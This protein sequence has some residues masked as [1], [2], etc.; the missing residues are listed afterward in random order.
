MKK[1]NEKRTETKWSDEIWISSGEQAQVDWK[2]NI[3]LISKH[4]EVFNINVFAMVL[5]FSRRKY[6]EVTL[7]KNQHILKNCIINAFEF[8]QGVTKEVLFDNMKTVVDIDKNKVKINNKFKAF[9]NDLG[10]VPKLCQVRRPQTKGK[11][12]TQMKFLDDLKLYNDEFESFDDLVRIVNNLQKTVNNQ[13]SQAHNQIPNLLYLKEK[14]YLIPIDL[15][16][17]KTLKSALNTHK[18][19]IESLISYKGNKYSVPHKLINKNVF[20]EQINNE[21]WIY[22]T[23]SLVAIHQV[24]NKKI[25]YKK[26]HYQ[27]IVNSYSNFIRDEIDDIVENNLKNFDKIGGKNEL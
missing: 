16:F 4:G 10:F 21:L 22:Y 17:S 15:K 27:G 6:F 11:V 9:A 5:S 7:F 25:N 24:S 26:D 8:F 20:V 14:E 2:E 23:T 19:S 18:V 13:V 3:K 1:W 12:E